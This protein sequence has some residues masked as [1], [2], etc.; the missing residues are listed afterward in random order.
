METEVTLQKLLNWQALQEM[1][2]QLDAQE[3]TAQ[4]TI[5]KRVHEPKPK[6]SHSHHATRRDSNSKTKSKKRSESER[7]RC[8]E[9][10][11][12]LEGCYFCGKSFP[13]TGV[14]PAKGKE[15]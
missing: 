11:Q 2:D 8:N 9:R 6:S 15:C 4:N 1:T 10:K 5:I 14:C 3:I 12:A 13:H 7:K